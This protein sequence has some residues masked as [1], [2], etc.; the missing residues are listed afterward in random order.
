M[1]RRKLSLAAAL[2]LVA[3]TI[4]KCLPAEAE[5]KTWT[6]QVEVEEL[7]RMFS[8]KGSSLK[9]VAKA[10]VKY[11]EVTDKAEP[12]PYETVWYH[13]GKP[14]G[15]E[16]PGQ[17]GVRTSDMVN[18]KVTQKNGGGEQVSKAA[19]FQLLRLALNAAHH[20]NPIL[21]MTVPDESFEE[22]CNELR[23]HNCVE[24]Q[25][26]EDRRIGRAIKFNIDTESDKH[27]RL[28]F[29]LEDK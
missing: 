12:K 3:L 14:I 15:M 17:Y 5:Q 18:I 2:C 23:R 13:D 11:S 25:Q 1:W 10:V 21:Y 7:Q 29:Q 26:E 8:Y 24:L 6:V 27:Q 4:F 19:A 28:Y 9:G 16:R 22:I 20:S